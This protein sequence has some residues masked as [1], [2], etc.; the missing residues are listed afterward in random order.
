MKQP[1][2]LLI[3]DELQLLELLEEI[4]VNKYSSFNIYSKSE[5]NSALPYFDKVDIIISDVCIKHSSIL[6]KELLRDLPNI[7]GIIRLTAD[8]DFIAPSASQ[9]VIFKPFSLSH[10]INLIDKMLNLTNK[11]I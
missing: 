11:E 2:I 6:E 7:K 4:I 1:S 5:V 10:I 9:I 8:H 3:E